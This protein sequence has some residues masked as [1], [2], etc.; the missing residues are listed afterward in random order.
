MATFRSDAGLVLAMLSL[1]CTPPGAQAPAATAGDVAAIAR[2][3]IDHVTP[4][5]DFVGAAPAKLEWTAADGVD[6]YTITVTNEVDAVLVDYRGARGTSIDWPKQMTLEPGTYFWRV[7]GVKDGRGVADSG[8][9]AFVV[10][11]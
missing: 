11:D 5:P 8:R 4:K 9:A 3:R 6:S 2:H 7:V 10:T 1:A